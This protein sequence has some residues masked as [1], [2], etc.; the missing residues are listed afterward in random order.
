MG[1]WG[2]EGIPD[3]VRGAAHWAKMT[4]IQ[5]PKIDDVKELFVCDCDG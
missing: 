1:L 3:V 2:S 4:L 5:R